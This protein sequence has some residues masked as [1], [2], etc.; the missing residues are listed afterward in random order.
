MNKKIL[1]T[2]VSSIIVLAACGSAPVNNGNTNN[3]GSANNPDI[4]VETPDQAGGEQVMCTMDA[5]MC[6]DGSYVG[7]TGPNCEFAACPSEDAESELTVSEAPQVGRIMSP[8]SVFQRYMEENIAEVSDKEA[9][10]GGNWS[11]SNIENTGE[12]TAVVDYEDGHIT[13]KMEVKYEIVDDKVVIVEKKEL[14]S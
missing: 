13:G 10:L 14:E 2:M 9:V 3:N 11:V 12:G 7:R 1:L 4:A 6:P 5:K 8:E